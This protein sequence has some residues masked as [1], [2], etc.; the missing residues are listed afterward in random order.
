M[1]TAIPA[2]GLLFLNEG[3]RTGT[4]IRYGLIRKTD[5][6][7]FPK[8]TSALP[9]VIV[10]IVAMTILWI[11]TGLLGFKPSVVASNSMSPALKTGDV[12][13]SVPSDPSSIKVGDI[14]QYTRAGYGIS[15]T[16]RVVSI[17]PS[18]S[19]YLITTKGDANNVADD[20]ISVSGKI[21]KV[22]QVVPKIGLITIYLRDFVYNLAQVVSRGGAQ[23]S[24][25]PS[26]LGPQ[27]AGMQIIEEGGEK[28]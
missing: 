24:I 10:L 19:T 13:I 9:W 20:P 7:K 18:G 5:L 3:V 23:A 2:L 15:I 17:E 22:V 1:N 12:V 14:V 26:F 21:G 27:T 4:L 16:H 28:T 8:K 6:R 11:P 25:A